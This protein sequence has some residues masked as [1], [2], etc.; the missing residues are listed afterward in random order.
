M[1]FSDKKLWTKISFT[2]FFII[3]IL[4]RPLPNFLSQ[5]F[6]RN[7]LLTHTWW[8]SWFLINYCK[9]LKPL[10]PGGCFIV[11]FITQQSSFVVPAIQSLVPGVF[12][13]RT[14]EILYWQKRAQLVSGPMGPKQEIKK[15]MK[16]CPMV[17]ASNWCREVTRIKTIQNKTK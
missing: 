1:A 7:L 14:L 5:P 4:F 15:N 3:F 10:Y 13:S 11:Y 16:I 9:H 17:P 8:I 12:M 6:L 2:L